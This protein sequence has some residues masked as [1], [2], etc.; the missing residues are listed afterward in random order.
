M[1]TRSAEDSI[2]LGIIDLVILCE[3]GPKQWALLC[4]LRFHLSLRVSASGYALND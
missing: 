3:S 4:R 2:L 1:K